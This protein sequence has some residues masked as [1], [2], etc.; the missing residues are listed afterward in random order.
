MGYRMQKNE[1]QRQMR[2]LAAHGTS[3]LA[4]S[5]RRKDREEAGKESAKEGGP[6]PIPQLRSTTIQRNKPCP[7]GSGKKFKF[8]HLPGA[9]KQ[10]I[11]ATR[12]LRMGKQTPVQE[13][14]VQPLILEPQ[15]EEHAN[16]SA[17]QTGGDQREAETFT[18]PSPAEVAA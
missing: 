10:N 8:C 14:P 12:A 11:E 17:G 2:Q 13:A 9:V 7:C 16:A 4:A 18:L 3:S 6:P 15:G 5:R 1:Y